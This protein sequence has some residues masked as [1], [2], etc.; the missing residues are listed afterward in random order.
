MNQPP[1]GA[2]LNS[3]QQSKQDED[4]IRILAICHYVYAGLT[5]LSLPFLIF[6]FFFMRTVIAMDSSASSDL[7]SAMGFFTAFYLVI[8]LFILA[9]I[10]LN[11]LVAHFLKQS[12]H[13]L[14]CLIVSGL[15]CISFPL[16]TTLGVFTII[17]ILRPS[18]TARFPQSRT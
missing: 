15:N 5:A 6:H 2:L 4:H 9:E 3:S 12:R 1:P 14:F 10:V 13:R 7:D 18:V 11:V 8:G 16:G 17:V